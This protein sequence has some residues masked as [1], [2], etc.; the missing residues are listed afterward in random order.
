VVLFQWEWSHVWQWL[1]PFCRT[2]GELTEGKVVLSI[3]M[4]KC[5]TTAKRDFRENEFPYASTSL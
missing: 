3:F 1:Q 5:V 2:Q 4:S